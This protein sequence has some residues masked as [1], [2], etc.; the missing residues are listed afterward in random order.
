MKGRLTTSSWILPAVGFIVLMGA[1]GVTTKL[2]LNTISWQQLVYWMPLS[3]AIWVIIL[4]LVYK[5]PMAFG[6]GGAWAAINAVALSGALILFF[7]ALT[8]GE[9]SIVIPATSAYPVV[10]L[11]ASAIF[12]SE[13]V[14]TPKVI[15]TILVVAGVVVISR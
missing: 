5:K 7:L 2:A 3:Y 11:I 9:V 15:G 1:S 4:A 13:S 10:A 8:K 14:T 6:S 12:L